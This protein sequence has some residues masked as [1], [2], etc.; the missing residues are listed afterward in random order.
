MCAYCSCSAVNH[1]VKFLFFTVQRENFIHFNDATSFPCALLLNS[2]CFVMCGLVW[3]T[4]VS[5]ISEGHVII[6][7]ERRFKD[8]FHSACC[9]VS[10]KFGP[11]VSLFWTFSVSRHHSWT[12]SPVSGQ[13]PGVQL[14]DAAVIMQCML[15]SV[16]ALF[17][18]LAGP[19]THFKQSRPQ[20]PNR[21]YSERKDNSSSFII[22][23]CFSVAF[24]LMTHNNMMY[25]FLIVII[26]SFLH[27][28]DLNVIGVTQESTHTFSMTRALV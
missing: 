11:C 15:G 22:H 23:L 20:D 4:H 27:P 19:E 24:T 9:W 17:L 14:A 3:F 26:A 28:R 10:C 7:L 21:G 8:S 2:L 18:H 13:K 25:L 5:H 1:A 12:L 6:I 16:M